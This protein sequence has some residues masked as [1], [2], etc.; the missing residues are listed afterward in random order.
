MRAEQVAIGLHSC[1]YSSLG[2]GQ[3][4][5]R[6]RAFESNRVRGRALQRKDCTHVFALLEWVLAAHFT[7]ELKHD[8]LNNV[9][10]GRD[11][12]DYRQ[13]VLH[14]ALLIAVAEHHKC[15]ALR[16]HVTLAINELSNQLWCVW[17]QVLEALVCV[18]NGEH[19]ISS[20]VAVSMLEV[21]AQRCNQRL[22]DVLLAH[23]AE[24]S[25][26]G[27]TNKLVGVVEIVSDHVTDE[28]HLGQQA[29]VGRALLDSLEVQVE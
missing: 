27:A 14:S 18:V 7:D 19:G 20:H 24:K 29:A 23:F 12:V 26:R 3:R 28:N 2:I 6:R 17:H 1:G 8:E 9:T 25:Q 13:L 21:G 22:Q 10:H 15:I 16:R 4:H 11:G 5:K